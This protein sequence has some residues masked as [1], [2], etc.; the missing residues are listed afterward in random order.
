LM[1]ADTH[2]QIVTGSPQQISVCLILSTNVCGGNM[3]M[4]R[5]TLS[6]VYAAV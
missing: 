6:R 5:C 1:E 3:L 4:I 2:R